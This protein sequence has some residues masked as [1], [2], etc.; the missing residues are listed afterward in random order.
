MVGQDIG[1]LCVLHQPA[2]Y[3]FHHAVLYSRPTT[4][5]LAFRRCPAEEDVQLLVANTHTGHCRHIESGSR[6]DYLPVGISRQGRSQ[7]AAWRLWQLCKDCYDYGA[8]NPGIPLC[9]RAYSL[10]EEQGCRQDRVLRCR[11]EV[12]PHLHAACL[13]V[14]CRMDAPS[15]IYNR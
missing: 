3:K 1:I 14:C 15:A 4:H 12:L 6:Q 9:L 5:Q 13:P 11:N 7:R 2:V 8:D 10:C